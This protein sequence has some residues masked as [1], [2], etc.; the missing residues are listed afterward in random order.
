[1]IEWKSIPFFPNYEASTDGRI[2]NLKGREISQQEDETSKGTY[3]SVNIKHEDGSRRWIGVHRLV[4]LAFHGVH[5]DFPKIDTNHND[6]NKHN[7][8]E[9]NVG[10]M[11][12]SDN[13]K[14][15]Y[16]NGLNPTVVTVTAYDHKTESTIEFNSLA[17]LIAFF[18]IEDTLGMWFVTRYKTKRYKGRYT[19]SVD[20]YIS[21]N[22]TRRVNVCLVD[23]IN[24]RF[25]RAESINQ[26]AYLTDLNA[27]TIAKYLKEKPYELLRGC[28][29]WKHGD[30]K[31]IQKISEITDKDVEESLDRYKKLGGHQYKNKTR[32]YLV[33][34]YRTGNEKSFRYLR[35]AAEL[36]GVTRKSLSSR[37]LEGSLNL[38]N[39]YS[40]KRIED[41]RL[42]IEHSP[43]KIKFSLEGKLPNIGKM[44]KVTDLTS[45]TT[46]YY[47]SFPVFARSIGKDPETLR[48]KLKN[49]SLKDYDVK[50][51]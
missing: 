21:A 46:E 11:S 19:F 29:F 51:L 41:P 49:G 22:S 27:A 31:F 17:E 33:R 1:M 2:R 25:Y 26:L 5:K 43:L 16:I 23:F 48:Q 36:I 38:I 30:K 32:G 37:I 13:V 4:C 7:N 18:G 3:L 10:W 28:L 24:D 34:D 8:S 9:S 12:R 6:G 35:E 40:I 14:H 39:G 44:V 50:F 45:N 20:N 15:A 42:F 47:P